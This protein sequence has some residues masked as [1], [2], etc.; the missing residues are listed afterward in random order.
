LDLLVTLENFDLLV[1]LS[2]T[3]KFFN[4]INLLFLRMKSKSIQDELNSRRVYLDSRSVNLSDRYPLSQLMVNGI[5]VHRVNLQ[6]KVWF[7]AEAI[8]QAEE[9]SNIEKYL[10]KNSKTVSPPFM[11]IGGVQMP[12]HIWESIFKDIDQDVRSIPSKNRTRSQTNPNIFNIQTIKDGLGEEFVRPGD[13]RSP[14]WPAEC[15]SEFR[16]MMLEILELFTSRDFF[17][18]GFAYDIDL[19]KPALLRSDKE[20]PDALRAAKYDVKQLRGQSWHRDFDADKFPRGQAARLLDCWQIP[21]IV[22]LV[23]LMD[24][25]RFRVYTKSHRV[26]MFSNHEWVELHDGGTEEDGEVIEITLHC[27]CIFIMHGFT[28]HAGCDY[29]KNNIRCVP[30]LHFFPT[31]SRLI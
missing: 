21:G 18:P 19:V 12:T 26:C 9:F 24:G 1:L 7:T 15:H 3:F 23:C 22:I 25:T 5:A 2:F 14:P 11:N 28:I 6:E 27:G 16:T 17:V 30:C 29:L 13:Q 31:F 4:F 8:R 10:A 20:G